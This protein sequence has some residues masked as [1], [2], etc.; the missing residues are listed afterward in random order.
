MTATAST[1][2]AAYWEPLWADGRHYRQLC[3]DE[4]RLIGFVHVQ[5]QRLS[6]WWGGSGRSE[7]A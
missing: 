1:A 7:R 3:E 6:T 2:S 4:K 5:Q